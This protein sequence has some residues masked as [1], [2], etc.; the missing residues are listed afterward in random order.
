MRKEITAL[1]SIAV[2]AVLL[3]HAK[4]PYFSSAYLGVD[5]FFVISGYLITGKILDEMKSGTFTIKGFY[6]NRMF[7]LERFVILKIY[8][9]EVALKLNATRNCNDF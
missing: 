4:I 3:Y 9:H 5:V 2:I 7:S 1:R 6:L 8:F